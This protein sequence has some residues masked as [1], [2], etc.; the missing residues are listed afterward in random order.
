MATASKQSAYSLATYAHIIGWGMALP[1]RIMTNDDMSAIVET[2]DKWIVE[3]TGIR[4]RRIASE[5]ESTATLALKAAQKALAVANILPIELDMI[6][7][8]TST[9]EYIFPS[10]ASIVQN[11]LGASKAGAFD[12]SA[13]CSGFV[14]ALNMA[15]QSIRTRSIQTAL[16]IGAET[17]SRIIDWTDRSTCILFGDGAG[18]VVLRASSTPGGILSS[19]L[20]SDGAGWDVLC[21]PSVGSRDLNN[22]IQPNGHKSFRMYMDG[23]ETFKFATRVVGESISQAVSDAGLTLDDIKLIVPHQANLRIISAAARVLKIEE[24][25]FMVNLD[26][27]GNTS[28]A[29]IPIALVEAVQ[30][31]K[32]KENDYLAFCGFGGGLAWGSMVVKWG[33]P[34]PKTEE[35]TILIEQRRQLS[36]TLA[37]LRTRLRKF[38][39]FWETLFARFTRRGRIQRL[40]DRVDKLD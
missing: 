18:A 29:S 12:M 5:K 39:K 36:Y 14:Y 13:A 8:A 25:R 1:E 32:V 31:G 24:S 2:D 21:L 11:W 26:R 7:V 9:P 19:V 15:S 38:G 30:Q 17:M 20:R 34:K 27:Y 16:V 28:A 33:A 35:R 4:E 23:P 3:R 40:R 6:I 22:S 10:T 37:E